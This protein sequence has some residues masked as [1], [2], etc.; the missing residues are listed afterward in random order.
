MSI[1][2]G[3]SLCRGAAVAAIALVVGA[4]GYNLV[5]RSTTLP[6]SIQNIYI[7]PLEN[8]TL[9]SQ[10]DIILTS[11]ITEEFV[12]RQRYEVVADRSQ[13]DAELVGVVTGFST[14]PVAFDTDDRANRYEI[15]ITA[16]VRLQSMTTPPRL[17]WAN[18]RYVFRQQYQAN[19]AEDPAT[20]AG[21]FI[22]LSSQAMEDVAEE[23]AQ[24]LVIDVL[25]GF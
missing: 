10:V 25:E 17:H 1:E 23:F 15:T 8:R 11:A 12:Q 14:T 2:R 9:R 21:V 24:S 7:A 4:C 18:D 13:A 19:Q 6:A 20:G 3:P 5:G 16:A 22:D